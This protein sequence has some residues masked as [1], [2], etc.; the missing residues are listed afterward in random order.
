MTRKFGF[1]LIE[2]LVVIAIIAILA[3][4][5][6]PVFMRAKEAAYRSGDMTSLNNIRNGLQLYRADQEAYPPQL[7]G[8][9]TNYTTGPQAGQIIPANLLKAGLYPRRIDSI[10][11]LKPAYDRKSMTDIVPAAW[12]S[13][14]SRPA[15]SA[16][17]LDLNGDGNIVSSLAEDD[18]QQAR[19]AY[20]SGNNCSTTSTS[21]CVYYINDGSPS[22]QWQVG[23]N[24]NAATKFYAV[25]GYDVG[26]VKAAPGGD[27]NRRWE[28]HYT[29]RWT[30]WG[31]SGGNQR[32]DP[33]QL[34]YS[35][36][37]DN[38]VI[39]WD[40]WFRDYTSGN[41]PVRGKKD[42]V[43]FLGGGARPYDSADIADRSWR[44]LP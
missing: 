35:E 1:T 20:A 38:T 25:S 3:A 34:I 22:F 7:L 21:S 27:E 36:P 13:A 28:L 14:D 31:V 43:L 37:P 41:L 40:A 18:P 11:S 4:I 33:R 26:E 17:I 42:F 8:Y 16:A 29:L 39:T 5:I 10:N 9:V 23:N 12:P 2:L 30:N 19:Q 15:G 32:D 6:F 44:V 24:A